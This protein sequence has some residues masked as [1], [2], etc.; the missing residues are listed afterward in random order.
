MILA[1]DVH[2]PQ[3]RPPLLAE[4]HQ[5][6]FSL[7]GNREADHVVWTRPQGVIDDVAPDRLTTAIGA[8]PE[9]RSSGVDSAVGRF[10]RGLR[11]TG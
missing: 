4:A 5:A 9:S 6:A 8:P 1:T 3:R 10:L 11:R 7:V 2:H